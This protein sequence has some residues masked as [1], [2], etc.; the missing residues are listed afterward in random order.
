MRWLIAILA[1]WFVFGPTGASAEIVRSCS[2]QVFGIATIGG[3]GTCKNKAH[4]NDCRKHAHDAILDCAKALYAAR[5]SGTKLPAACRG[6]GGAKRA[7][8]HWDQII[9]GIRGDNLGDRIRWNECCR[10]QNPNRKG[11]TGF[12]VRVVGD[13][14]C[15]SGPKVSKN[16][17]QDDIHIGDIF[18]DC[19]KQ[20]QQGL[21]GQ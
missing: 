12:S 5:A 18:F 8:L 14:G 10:G 20:R 7:V 9:L 11:K 19:Q 1:L 21:C 15:A 16:T 17:Y 2:G 4:A 13:K 3:E 6:G